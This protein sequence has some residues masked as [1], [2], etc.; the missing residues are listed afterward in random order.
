MRERVDVL[1]VEVSAIDP[2]IAI[3]TISEWIDA[4]S[5]EYVC[6]T[7]VHGVMESQRDPRLKEI[8]NSAGL[9]TPDGM[10]MVWCGR[11]AG[12][13]W[14]RRVYG[15][16]LMLNVCGESERTGWRHFLYGAA[17]GVAEELASNLRK[18]FP[19]IEIVGTHT[20]PF[21]ELSDEEVQQTAEMI[22]STRPHIVWVGLSTPK[23]ERWMNRFRE[24]LDVPVLIGVGA[25]FDLHT[26]RV[27]QAPQWMGR[28]GLEWA[29]RL[30]VEPKRLWRRYLGSIPVFLFQIVRRPP[31]LVTEFSQSKRT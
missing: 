15:P 14:M 3:R 22:N 7:G 25:A 26:G 2:D 30:S 13:S 17:E 6:V 28:S 27:P 24:L 10:P 12:A 5:R 20:P 29:F 4:G 23:Q 9:V 11:L 8:H 16:D 1:G 19:K 21:R 31:R 18:L